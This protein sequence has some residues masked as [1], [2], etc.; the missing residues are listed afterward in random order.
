[1]DN[2][3]KNIY[4]LVLVGGILMIVINVSLVLTGED[5]LGRY[6]GVIAGMAF[7]ISAL[8]NLKNIKK[9]NTQ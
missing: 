4:T 3:K 2:K 9:N 1:M 5:S 6:L 7:M 8:I